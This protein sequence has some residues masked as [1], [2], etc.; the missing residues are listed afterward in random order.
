MTAPTVDREVLARWVATYERAMAVSGLPPHVHFGSEGI[1]A[2]YAAARAYLDQRPESGS[3]GGYGRRV[4]E[5]PCAAAVAG[6]REGNVASDERGGEV[7]FVI[8]IDITS[9]MR[10]RAEF[11]TA[12][13]TVEFRRQYGDQQP[14]VMGE[15]QVAGD[16][17]RSLAKGVAAEQ[18]ARQQA[19]RERDAAVALAEKRE[20]LWQAIVEAQN[21]AIH[22]TRSEIAD[23]MAK[24]VRLR[25]A[26]GLDDS[27]P[28]SK[29][30][31][32]EAPTDSCAWS[33]FDAGGDT[34]GTDCGHEFSLVVDGPYENEMRFCCYCGK[35]LV[36]VKAEP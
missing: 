24:L 8:D 36:A 22:G 13:G 4:H 33:Q 17:E 19:E 11:R 10:R 29:P 6:R 14:V 15:W 21:T 18:Q 7:L 20:A 25:T 27:Q 32:S 2:L 35:S 12:N 26:L 5:A 16:I 23:A 34:Y 31:E 3:D 30:T 1:A 28:T 9:Q